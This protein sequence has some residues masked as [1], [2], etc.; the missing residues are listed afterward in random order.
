MKFEE[1]FP[2]FKLGEHQNYETTCIVKGGL[3]ECDTCGCFTRWSDV[4]L[5]KIACSEECCA[6]LWQ[7]ELADNPK[8]A[9][10]QNYAKYKPEIEKELAIAAKHISHTKDIIIV[11]RDQLNYLKECIQSIQEHTKNYKLYI[12]DNASQ[13]DTKCYLERLLLNDFDNVE[14]MR[15]EQNMGFIQPN[16]E[17]AAWGKSDYIILLN[18]DTK[19]V[20]GWD[21]ALI[22]H[23][24]EQPEIG[25]IGYLGGLL[26]ENCMGC[27]AD[28]GWEIDYVM[29][30]CLCISRKTYKTHGLFNQQ[31]KFA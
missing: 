17:M 8:A 5:N 6:Q 13:E 22:G 30:W 3:G 12:W 25:V 9:I 23:L 24:I 16:N 10:E 14:L 15:S 26:D 31:L 4:K 1:K 28:Y 21:S 20:E 11:V 18:S 19:V 7:Q 29:G 2:N 27:G